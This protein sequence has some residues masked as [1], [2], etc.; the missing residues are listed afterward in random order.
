MHKQSFEKV[1]T[2]GGHKYVVDFDIYFDQ[3]E[4]EACIGRVEGLTGGYISFAVLLEL[5]LNAAA[6]A[7]QWQDDYYNLR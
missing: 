7:E 3:N 6:Y 4:S 2:V 5:R 1:W